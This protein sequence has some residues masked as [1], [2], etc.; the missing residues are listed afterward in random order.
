MRW[1]TCESK[2]IA[3]VLHVASIAG[4][5]APGYLRRDSKLRRAAGV[6][7]V[8]LE[9]DMKGLFAAL[10][11]AAE[12][13]TSPWCRHDTQ[14]F[15]Q[16]WDLGEK[17]SLAEQGHALVAG[18][19]SHQLEGLFTEPTKVQASTALGAR[20][21]AL[22]HP[23]LIV[24]PP[25]CPSEVLIVSTL[26]AEII[27]LLD[28]DDL[29]LEERIWQSE[30]IAASLMRRHL[31]DIV[32]MDWLKPLMAHFLPEFERGAKIEER[33]RRI[34]EVSLDQPPGEVDRIALGFTRRL[35]SRFD[36]ALRR[37]FFQ[38]PRPKMESWIEDRLKQGAPL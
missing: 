18:L 1:E 2:A 27:H 13:G 20:P 16:R 30:M 25:K 4:L 10:T 7:E 12:H 32:F 5:N 28:E 14:W 9:L 36:R 17:S 37:S 31:G 38:P 21:I 8:S 24:A 19:Q 26:G 23:K 15:T 6:K 3:Q 11:K 29:E 22:A 35:Q 33:V 34:A